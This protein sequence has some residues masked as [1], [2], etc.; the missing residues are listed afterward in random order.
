MDKQNVV[1]PYNGIL[2]GR[3]KR[4][5]LIHA[6][7]WMDLENIMLSARSQ[8]QKSNIILFHSYESPE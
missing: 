7:L 4:M 6:T 2:F 5:I 8:S 3:K 1:H